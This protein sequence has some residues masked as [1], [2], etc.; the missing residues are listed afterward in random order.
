MQNSFRQGTGAD[1]SSHEHQYQNEM[2]ISCII[3]TRNR[4]ELTQRAIR[5]VLSQET[6]GCQIEIVVVDD[7]SSD[8]TPRIIREKYPEVKLVEN[9]S[10]PSGPGVARNIGADAA[11]GEILMFLDSDDLWHPCHAM[12]LLQGTNGADASFCSTLN[13]RAQNFTHG[14]HEIPVEEFLVPDPEICHLM[15]KISLLNILARW[16][17]IMPSSFAIR[18]TAFREIGGFPAV[19]MGEDWLFFLKA[20]SRCEIKFIREAATIRTLHP[21]MS[22]AKNCSSHEI[23]R[24]FQQVQSFVLNHHRLKEDRELLNWLERHEHLINRESGR[25]NHIQD[26]FSALK[27]NGML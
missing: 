7:A 6:E 27:R 22:C 16:C 21:D 17:C 9:G 4:E 18:H 14:S 8:D 10:G 2:L 23:R 20:A 24:I 3:P 13:R 15:G 25:W 12:L 11:S 19:A 26:W 5:S 1:Y